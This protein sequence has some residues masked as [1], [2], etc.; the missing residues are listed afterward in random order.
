LLPQT[1]KPPHR[2]PP[3]IC[4]NLSTRQFKPR[5]PPAK[6]RETTP[7][8]LPPHVTPR[9]PARRGRTPHRPR[10][11]PTRISHRSPAR[12]PLSRLQDERDEPPFHRPQVPLVVEFCRFSALMERIN[13]STVYCTHADTKPAL[14]WANPPPPASS[15]TPSTLNQ[16][17]LLPLREQTRPPVDPPS[18]PSLSNFVGYFPS[19]LSE[20]LSIPVSRF[21]RQNN[22]LFV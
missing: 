19:L 20:K 2:L 12:Q 18:T 15:P 14:P 17:P 16:P 9:H 13:P 1:S 6:P 3:Q 11:Q 21:T 8:P 5:T 22:L 7:R 4:Q 10:K